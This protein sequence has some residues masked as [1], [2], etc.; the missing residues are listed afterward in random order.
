MDV[1]L[2]FSRQN[3]FVHRIQH[4][5]RSGFLTDVPYFKKPCIVT[6]EYNLATHK[7]LLRGSDIF[8][9]EPQMGF[10]IP[11]VSYILNGK[12]RTGDFGIFSGPRRVDIPGVLITRKWRIKFRRFGVQISKDEWVVPEWSGT[13]EVTNLWG[14]KRT[15]NINFRLTEPDKI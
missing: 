10:F 6:Y 7:I 12:D 3:W 4:V 1:Y 5:E 9:P 2:F 14:Q 11:D 8:P 15:Q 13:L